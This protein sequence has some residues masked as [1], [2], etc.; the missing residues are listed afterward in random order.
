MYAIV[1]LTY[2][3]CADFIIIFFMIQQVNTQP[4]VTT[5]NG[6]TNRPIRAPNAGTA[7]EDCIV[8]MFRA[9]LSLVCSVNEVVGDG[10]M[11]TVIG[12]HVSCIG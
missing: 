7:L 2:L 12:V 3:T 10:Y 8:F 11:V 4:V 9:H 1:M 5:A 6:T